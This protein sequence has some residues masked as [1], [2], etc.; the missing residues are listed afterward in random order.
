VIIKKGAEINFQLPS[1]KIEIQFSLQTLLVSSLLRK[2]N[3]PSMF[4]LEMAMLH[5][6]NGLKIISNH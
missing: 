3:L 6:L 5:Y 4:F 1:L 2:A